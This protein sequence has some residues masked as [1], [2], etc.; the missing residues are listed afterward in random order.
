MCSDNDCLIRFPRYCSYN[1]VL[2]PVVLKWLHGRAVV[3]STGI[4][5]CVMNLAQKPFGGLFSIVGFIIA[6]MKGRE[7]LQVFA[8][9]LLF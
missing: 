2:S 5:K 3:E 1:A 6:S 8:H 4:F 7:I 9:V